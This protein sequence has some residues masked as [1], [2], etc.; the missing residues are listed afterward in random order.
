MGV[1]LERDPKRILFPIGFL[2]MAIA[3]VVAFSLR[4][5]YVDTHPIRAAN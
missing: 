3:N 5:R 4:S 1:W 2:A